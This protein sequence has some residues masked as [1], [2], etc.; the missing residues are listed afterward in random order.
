MFWICLTSKP[1]L[2]HFLCLIDYDE[3]EPHPVRNRVKKPTNR[4][5]IS[6]LICVISSPFSFRGQRPKLIGCIGNG[7]VS[8]PEHCIDDVL[9]RLVLEKRKIFSEPAQTSIVNQQKL[10]SVR[11]TLKPA[12]RPDGVG[13]NDNV[14]H[15]LKVASNVSC[16]L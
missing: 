9:S 6:R 10:N 8:V 12:S 7:L 13:C 11:W 14:G 15:G 5:P 4:T 1:F 2:E 16:E 3:S